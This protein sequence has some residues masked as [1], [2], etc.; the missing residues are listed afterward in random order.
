MDCVVEAAARGSA[1]YIINFGV[2]P[3]D[4]T[5]QETGLSTTALQDVSLTEVISCD[6]INCVQPSE[7]LLAASC[8]VEEWPIVEV[9][10]VVFVAN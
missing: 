3:C 8:W 10:K 6:E 1:D 7:I 5:L 2:Q 4:S 9:C